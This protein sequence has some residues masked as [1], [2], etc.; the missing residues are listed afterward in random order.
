VVRT[1]TGLL[2]YFFPTML[3]VTG[4]TRVGLLLVG[5]LTVALIIGAIWAPHT[6]G[7]TL[8]EI[9]VERYGAPVKTE[10]VEKEV[11]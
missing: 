1:V 7:K 8:K 9:E 5:L 6:R 3:A 4:L 10:E 11:V 2:S